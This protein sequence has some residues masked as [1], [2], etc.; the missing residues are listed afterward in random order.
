M[1]RTCIFLADGFETIEALTV[2][3]ML[4]R[5]GEEITMVSIT[6]DK[7]VQSSHRVMV[8]ADEIF[9]NM[10]FSDI[11]VLVLPGGMPGTTNLAACEKLKQ[12]IQ[13]HFSEGK[14]LAAICAAPGILG[15]MGLLAGK[16][17]CCFPGLE[18]KLA[19]A[20]VTFQETTVDGN[21]ITARGMGTSI[22]FAAEILKKT[23]GENTAQE[24]L[25]KI[26]YRQ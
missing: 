26:V 2:V 8:E 4:R 22:V 21:V 15:E 13:K 18:E 6:G 9:D 14:L 11:D 19:G 10:H 25:N 20:E 24:I 1:S 7:R 5:A 3:D 17:A 16:K 12:L 23:A